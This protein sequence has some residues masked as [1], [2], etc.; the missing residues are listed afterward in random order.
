MKNEILS[1]EF[2]KVPESKL[3]ASV[4]SQAIQDRDC[5]YLQSPDALLHAYC[6]DIPRDLMEMLAIQFAAPLMSQEGYGPTTS[7]LAAASQSPKPHE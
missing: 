4:I 2:S 3:W 5:S 1:S 6:A 7:G